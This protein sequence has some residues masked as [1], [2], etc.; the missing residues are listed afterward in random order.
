[1]RKKSFLL[2]LVLILSSCDYIYINNSSKDSSLENSSSN[3]SSENSNEPSSELS[4][5]YSSEFSSIENSSPSFEGSSA[6]SEEISSPFE[7]SSP[8]F[9]G[10]SASF[11][12]SSSPF[13]DSSAPSEESSSP[14]ED[15]S[16]S[17]EE[18]SV[19]SEDN[20]SP[21]ISEEPD[22]DVSPTNYYTFES[23]DIL[24]TFDEGDTFNLSIY[25]NYI[26]LDQEGRIVYTVANS[27]CGY[28]IKDY[29]SHPLY[30]KEIKHHLN[31]SNNTV[32]IPQGCT[33][34]SISFAAYG[35]FANSLSKGVISI[36]YFDLYGY[37]SHTRNWNSL[38]NTYLSIENGV[39]INPT[40]Y[41]SS[42][43]ASSFSTYL[44]VGDSSQINVTILPENATDKSVSF[45]SSNENVATVSSTG[46]VIAKNAGSVRITIKSSNGKTAHID[47]FIYA[48]EVEETEI[49]LPSL[50]S[51]KAVNVSGSPDGNDYF[52]A[53]ETRPDSK[54]VTDGVVYTKYNYSSINGYSLNVYTV[55][56]DLNKVT[57]E[58]GTPNNSYFPTA[59]SV[60]KSQSSSYESGSG[61]K[62]YAAVN[63]DFF[64]A[65]AK[66][67]PNG[68]SVKDGVVVSNCSPWY[69]SLVNGMWA[70]SVSYNNIASI[71]KSANSSS[72]YYYVD[73]YISLYSQKASVLKTV[74]I[75]SI[76]NNI[77]YDPNY[78]SSRPINN[79][80][81]T[82]S[83]LNVKNKNVVYVKKYKTYD[84][85]NG[86]INFPFDARI[87]KIA[88]NFTGTV[89]LGSNEVALLVDSSFVS[90]AKVDLRVRVG[91]TD[92]TSSAFDNV[93]TLVGGRHLLVSN[94]KEVSNITSESTNGANSRRARTA[95][96]LMKDGKVMLFACNDNAGLTLQQ[97]ADF[98]AYYGC[99]T[100]MNLDGGG[101]TG[102]LIREN[103][104]LTLKAGANSRSV[105][106]TLLVV[107]KD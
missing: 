38:D 29:Y 36:D 86:N 40:I 74:K 60:L 54:S 19:P 84:N 34:Y 73:N 55:T 51:R 33:G 10:S 1:M 101:S 21:S 83:G 56:I 89:S 106:N 47:F 6:S 87:T 105:A 103:N 25:T 22:Y 59:F 100:A 72:S 32:T 11:E 63:A 82:T 76:N 68:F 48:K 57:I 64:G 95:I 27:G 26:I 28:G 81:I 5:L 35:A 62:V 15:S 88:K 92:S 97:V 24:Q 45:T 9:E 85:G 39:K 79:G 8:S 18:S 69:E 41:V 16:P 37:G 71:D 2:I 93:K 61:R 104:S 17:F 7:D 77:V 30:E 53:A 94:Y 52:Y 13:E 12:E 78:G 99:H 50:G 46:L 43:T 70:F 3:I 31:S 90:Q 75:D 91:V 102:L 65:G 4:S 49:S 107:E 66:G 58:L 96:G 42:I 14:S 80:V 20:S 23:V 67:M 98:M 44:D